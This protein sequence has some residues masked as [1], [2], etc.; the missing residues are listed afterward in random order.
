MKHAFRSV[1]E[2]GRPLRKQ[3]EIIKMTKLEFLERFHKFA[4]DYHGKFLNGEETAIIASNKGVS[5]ILAI[6]DIDEREQFSI[7]RE[8]YS[9]LPLDNRGERFILYM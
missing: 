6:Y 5:E 1:S 8:Q 7:L 4:N 2:H 9:E 3:R